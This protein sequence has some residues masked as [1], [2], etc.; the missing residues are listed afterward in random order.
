MAASVVAEIDL[1]CRCLQETTGNHCDLMVPAVIV[2]DGLV[3][4]SR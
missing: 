3:Y 2:V 1:E 4:S